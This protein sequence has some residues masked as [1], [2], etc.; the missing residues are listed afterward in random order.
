LGTYFDGPFEG[1]TSVNEVSGSIIGGCVG[2]IVVTEEALSPVTGR[3]AT[4]SRS[5]ISV[6]VIP[7]EVNKSHA[8]PFQPP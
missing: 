6:E 2:V 7:P 1:I 4:P 8:G 5:K 3:I